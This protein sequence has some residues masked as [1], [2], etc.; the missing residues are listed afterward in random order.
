M[1]EGVRVPVHP[2]LFSLPIEFAQRDIELTSGQMV[3]D[4]SRGYFH[5]LVSCNNTSFI[6]LQLG[7][8]KTICTKMQKLCSMGCSHEND[9][10]HRLK[11]PKHVMARIIQILHVCYGGM[12]Y[13]EISPREHTTTYSSQPLNTWKSPACEVAKQVIIECHV[14]ITSKLTSASSYFVSY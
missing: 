12:E 9:I 7:H 1:R 5:P 3:A 2:M 10:Q 8:E 4:R 6:K 14:C 13:S 11:N